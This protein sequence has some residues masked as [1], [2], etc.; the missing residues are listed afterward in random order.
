MTSCAALSAYAESSVFKRSGYREPCV[1]P[2]N[3]WVD[4]SENGFH[5]GR[6][7]TE[8]GFYG[9]GKAFIASKSSC[10]RTA[11]SEDCLMPKATEG[12]GG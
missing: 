2:I 11:V 3:P 4:I 8:A 1:I 10:A 9:H 12:A 5:D 7:R 6:R